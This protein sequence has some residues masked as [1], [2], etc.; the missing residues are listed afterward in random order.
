MAIEVRENTKAPQGLCV[1][2]KKTVFLNLDPW[3]Q[4]TSRIMESHCP[5]CRGKLFT[6]LLIIMHG[7]LPGLAET[8][9]TITNV[10]NPDLVKYID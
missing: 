4:D 9:K 10:L 3:K 7:S 5:F 6:G 2:C 1:H 8:I